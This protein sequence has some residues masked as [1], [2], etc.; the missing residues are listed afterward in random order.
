M[1]IVPIYYFM[2]FITLTHRFLLEFFVNNHGKLFFITYYI[3]GIYLF[4]LNYK[5]IIIIINVSSP[6]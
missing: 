5:L 1:N 2:I 6:G 4:T 3:S